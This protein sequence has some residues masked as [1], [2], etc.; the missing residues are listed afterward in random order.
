MEERSY[1]SLSLRE[2]KTFREELS[3]KAT[4]F[5]HGDIIRGTG[6]R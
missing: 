4:E 2:G 6:Y 5:D 3:H 1:H